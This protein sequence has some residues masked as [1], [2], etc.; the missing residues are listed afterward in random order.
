MEK[1][2]YIIKEYGVCVGKQS[3]RMV[4]RKD[5][6]RIKEIPFIFLRSLLPISFLKT[7]GLKV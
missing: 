7:C 3:E 5:G 6:K 1:I 4:V 2:N